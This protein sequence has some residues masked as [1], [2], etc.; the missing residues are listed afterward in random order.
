MR[1][2][3][4]PWWYCEANNQQLW[5]LKTF[6]QEALHL[7][8]KNLQRLFSSYNERLNKCF[9]TCGSLL[10]S[11]HNMAVLFVVYGKPT[12]V[13]SLAKRAAFL[14]PPVTA[15]QNKRKKHEALFSILFCVLCPFLT[16]SSAWGNDYSIK[17][18]HG[19]S[20]RTFSAISSTYFKWNEEMHGNGVGIRRWRSFVFVSLVVVGTNTS[21]AVLFFSCEPVNR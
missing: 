17:A 8:F 13:W 21:G 1:I 12:A 20:R 18:G 4:W 5:P 19:I 14:Q 15:S 16:A 11:S 7:K 10:K 2:P 6:S 9:T 3:W